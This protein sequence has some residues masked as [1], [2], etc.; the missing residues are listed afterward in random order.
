MGDNISEQP[1]KRFLAPSEI[2]ALKHSDS[3]LKSLTLSS[4]TSDL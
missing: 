4:S 3:D 1:C 2:E